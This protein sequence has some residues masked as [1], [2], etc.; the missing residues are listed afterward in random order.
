MNTSLNGFLKYSVLLIVISTGI[1][2]SQLDP[3]NITQFTE[4]DGVPGSQVSTILSDK[5]GFIWLGTINGLARYDGYE[6]K[7]FYNDPNDST[8]IK[9]L[10]VWSLFED[11]K[12]RIW[13]SSSPE[14]LNLY[15]PITKSFRQFE[16]KHLIERA[17]NVEIGITQMCKDD[18]GRVYL[19]VNSYH[20]EIL[21]S[22]LLYLDEETKQVK[23][24]LSTDSLIIQN[25]LSLTKDK[26]GNVWVL[27]Y[28]GLFKIDKDRQL[29]RIRYLDKDTE[30]NKEYLTDVKCDKSGDIWTI[31]NRSRLYQL[32]SAT[33]KY[34]SYYQSEFDKS[35][36]SEFSR[37]ILVFDKNEN[38]W[39]GSS[40][41]L[42]YFDRKKEKYIGFA[43]S[44]NNPI[45]DAYILDLKFDSFGSL[46]IGT[47]SGGLFKYEEKAVLKSYSFNS[48]DKNSITPGWVNH[49]Y[50][51]IDG[52]IWITTS[53]QGNNSGI[54]IFDQNTGS[55]KPIPFQNI[56]PGS[57]I[58]FGLFEKSPNE[59]LFSTVLG[60]FQYSAITNE[61]KKI[62]LSGVPPSSF[63]NQFVNDKSENLW[64]CTSDGLYKRSKG[65]ENFMRY[66][67][68]LLKGSNASSNEITGAFESKKHGLWLLTPNGLFLYNYT[69]DKIERH[70][71]DKTKGDILI[72]Q[73]INSL[74]E[75]HDGNVWVGAWQGGLSKYNVETKK[76]KTYT[77][78]DGLPS[79]ERSGYS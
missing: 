57:N 33:G 26:N 17:A 36:F 29:N 6:F 71:L 41:G 12:G 10:I 51:S 42:Y 23:K 77:R 50:E 18:E 48:S 15:N 3:S 74:F 62:T 64:L 58:I 21:S 1:S 27:S 30:K 46:W 44:S 52:K 9:G 16:Y 75:D 37:T 65:E 14:N 19:G 47:L 5:F 8:S 25:I 43:N 63:I 76:I 45:K 35:N 39:I 66:D 59:F 7:R 40:Q 78:N 24:F 4:K 53:G 55:L 34:T 73:D 28:N 54:N 60:F 20:G 72:S 49:I 31:T 56:L 22:A 70:G 11:K 13:V 2:F 32:N 69:T 67:L 38:I 79:D 61:V 68:T